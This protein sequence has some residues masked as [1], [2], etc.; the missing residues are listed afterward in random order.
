VNRLGDDITVGRRN[1][2]VKATFS[3]GRESVTR[4]RKPTIHISHFAE[5]QLIALV[6]VLTDLIGDA[7]GFSVANGAEPDQE[8]ILRSCRSS[9]NTHLRSARRRYH[10]W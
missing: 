6:R 1:A 10:G 9:I 7:F 3:S 8:A 5:W 2:Q 4:S